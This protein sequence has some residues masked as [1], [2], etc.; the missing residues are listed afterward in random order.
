MFDLGCDSLVYCADSDQMLKSRSLKN[1][2]AGNLEG[3]FSGPNTFQPNHPNNTKAAVKARSTNRSDDNGD[4]GDNL[5][6]GNRV[7]NGGARSQ[8]TGANYSDRRG[9][10]TRRPYSNGMQKSQKY[11]YYYYYY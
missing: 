1:R 4:G 7:A 3:E 9:T 10:G 2:G 6:Q 11:S 8:R 5:G